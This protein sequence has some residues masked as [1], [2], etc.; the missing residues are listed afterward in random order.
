MDAAILSRG[1]GE[2][3][4]D[5]MAW[6]RKGPGAWRRVFFEPPSRRRRRVL[7]VFAM[8]MVVTGPVACSGGQEDPEERS[9]SS[10]SSEASP[11][12]RPD[13][14]SQDATPSASAK[15]VDA[16]CFGRTVTIV[17]TAG[18]DR[19]VG[20]TSKRDVVW[21]MG[22][23]DV[24]TDVNDRDRVCAGGGDDRVTT[25]K[26]DTDLRVDLGA[27]DDIFRGA[28]WRL[29][30]GTGDDRLHVQ[31]LSEVE[32]GAGRDLIATKPVKAMY[33]SPCLSYTR[34]ARGIVANLT[35]GWVQAEGRD[36]VKGVQCLYGTRFADRVTGS[37]RNDE[38]WMCSRIRA[39]V[40]GRLC[41]QRRL[42]R[43]RKRRGPWLQRGRPCVPGRRE[44]HVHG[45]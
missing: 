4:G 16:E 35:R 34:L 42:R 44:G 3:G 15:S 23:D 11:T 32:P 38:L 21:A 28:A 20:D 26:G 5:A 30:G 9:A 8:V 27:G 6:R 37:P 36:Q 29:I 10:S 40:G 12:S 41:P 17:G 2:C 31:G 22:G 33:S 7:A 18:P 1:S 25:P 43:R 19:L 24:I 45:G 39:Q 14:P 13:E